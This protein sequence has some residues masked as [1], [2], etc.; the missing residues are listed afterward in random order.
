MNQYEEATYYDSNYM[1]FWKRQNYGDS[2][3]ISECQ[4]LEY[5]VM[6]TWDT[7]DFQGSKTTLHDTTMVDTCHYTFVKTHIMHMKSEP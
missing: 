3:K 4:E 1:T 5:R 2:E 6:N 7:E